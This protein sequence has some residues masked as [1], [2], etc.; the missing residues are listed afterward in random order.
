MC[1]PLVVMFFISSWNWGWVKYE[2]ILVFMLNNNKV[3]ISIMVQQYGNLKK[4]V[5]Q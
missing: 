4:Y 2:N 3:V 1:K 5:N